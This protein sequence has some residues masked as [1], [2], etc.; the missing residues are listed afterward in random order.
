MLKAHL[1][2]I[3]VKGHSEKFNFVDVEKSLSINGSNWIEDFSFFG[4]C[5]S[6]KLYA[7]TTR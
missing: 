4:I 3:N 2:C 6:Y 5:E 7:V 1:M